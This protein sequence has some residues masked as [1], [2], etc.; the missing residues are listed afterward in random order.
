MKHR[1]LISALLSLFALNVAAQ[2]NPYGIDDK[3]YEYFRM[4][5]S[6]VPDTSNDAFDYAND[7]LLKRAQEV[8]DEKARTIHYICKLKRVIRFAREMKDRAEGNETVENQKK[9]TVAIALETGYLQYFYYSYVLCQ[10]YYI[11]TKQEVHAMALLNEMMDIA[12]KNEDEYGIWQSHTYIAALY[13]HQ[14]DILNAR[15]HLQRAVKLFENSTDETL[16]R[17]SITRHCCDLA[18]TYTAGADSSRFYCRDAE[19]AAKTHQDT[20]RSMYYK[21]RLSAMDKDMTTYRHYRDICLSDS[22]FAPMITGGEWLFSRTD[23]I[24]QGAPRD[25]VIVRASKVNVRQQMLYLRD[26]SIASKREDV[27]AWMGSRIVS[28][29][30]SDIYA[31]NNMKMEELS[32]SVHQRQ[33]SLALQRQKRISRMLG[34]F[35][36]VLVA[37]LLAALSALY[38]RKQ[39]SKDND[40]ALRPES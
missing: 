21:A 27:A 9:E 22:E 10:N 12:L 19:E 25:S 37:A 34:L 18:D 28:T 26:L 38:L 4:A 11:N 13:Y 14:N 8:G 15:K 17:Q 20:L 24:L 23:A 6:L 39:K 32:S 16:R 7:A 35:A 1:L 31:L 40:T 3:C 5:E 36:G 2:T 33:L 30:Y 29:F